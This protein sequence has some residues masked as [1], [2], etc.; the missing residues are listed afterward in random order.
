MDATQQAFL[1]RLAKTPSD[2]LCHAVY[3]DYL[4]ERGFPH[5]AAW[6]RAGGRMT[7]EEFNTSVVGQDDDNDYS[8]SGYVACV[9]ER[10]GLPVGLLGDYSHCSCYGTWEALTV[11]DKQHPVWKWVGP[12]EELVEMARR[13]ADPILPTRTVAD[14]DHDADHLR[15]VYRQ[16]VKWADSRPVA[17]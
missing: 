2:E 12:A 5:A 10:A 15:A 16:V 4:D 17:P 11:D 8:E 7:E 3:A 14:E 6:H 13:D 1:N 9:V